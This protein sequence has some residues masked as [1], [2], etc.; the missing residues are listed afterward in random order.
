MTKTPETI[1]SVAVLQDKLAQILSKG[2]LYRPFIYTGEKLDITHVPSFESG[3]LTYGMLPK[4]IRMFCE[5]ARCN[6]EQWWEIY[7]PQIYFQERPQYVRYICKSCDEN[8][9][10]F[11]I[12]WREQSGEARIFVNGCGSAPD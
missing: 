12:I 4:T 7:D 2:T 11:W 3:Q 9:T 5:H 8:A 6:S 1:A 10:N